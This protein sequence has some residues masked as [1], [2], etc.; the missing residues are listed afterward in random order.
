MCLTSL[1]LHFVF[2]CAHTITAGPRPLPSPPFPPPHA[3]PSHR[4]KATETV[5][6]SSSALA[7]KS[8]GSGNFWADEIAW[9]RE[10]LAKAF[11]VQV[12]TRI[13]VARAPVL[14]AGA[15]ASLRGAGAC[16][17]ARQRGI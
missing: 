11:K 17:D 15:A 1:H 10:E 5:A 9:Q 2:L 4:A 16:A 14:P 8:T 6:F 12:R 13:A 3:S 7:D